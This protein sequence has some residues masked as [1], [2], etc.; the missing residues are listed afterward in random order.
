MSVIATF[1]YFCSWI[2]ATLSKTY[3]KKKK[4]YAYLGVGNVGNSRLFR[5]TKRN[6]FSRI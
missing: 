6:G 5:E 1:L 4:R 3:E 2:E